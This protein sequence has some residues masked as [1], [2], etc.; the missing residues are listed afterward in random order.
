MD[1]VTVKVMVGGGDRADNGDGD[2]G[3]G[4]DDNGG[5]DRHASRQ[6]LE[7]QT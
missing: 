5:T 7:N 2:S 6:L 4:G 1:V 3:S